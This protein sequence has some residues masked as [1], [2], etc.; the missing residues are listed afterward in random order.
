MA[1]NAYVGLGSNLSSPQKQVE[2]AIETINNLPNC[3]V[4]KR[5][6]IYV[7]DPVG[8]KH[9]PEFA[10]AVCQVI[11]S[12]VPITFLQTLLS[13]EIKTGRKRTRI[14][15]GPR[16]IDLDLL[17]FENERIASEELHIP[18]PRMHERRFVLEPLVEIAPE[19]HIPSF[20]SAAQLLKN[21]TNQRVEL[22]KAS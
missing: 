13:I 20:G 19:I 1:S 17:L 5:S 12:L 18:H 4:T 21:L 14:H 9:Q 16:I 6:S 11:T 3:T 10:N 2:L 7:S 8:Y 15:N 22:V